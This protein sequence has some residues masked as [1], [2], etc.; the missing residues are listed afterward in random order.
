M[1]LT[2]KEIR[3]T[4]AAHFVTVW[5]GRTPVIS[6]NATEWDIESGD[7]I[8]RVEFEFGTGEQFELTENPNQRQYG[9]IFFEIWQRPGEGTADLLELANVIVQGFKFLKLNGV[10]TQAVSFLPVPRIPGLHGQGLYVPFDG[11]V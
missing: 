2:P 9:N 5:N 4:L 3:E 8:V 6:E 10:S 7:T 1:V 11:V